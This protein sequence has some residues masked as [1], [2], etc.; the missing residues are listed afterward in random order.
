MIF[1]VGGLATFLW[2]TSGLS[3]GRAVAALYAGED[4]WI[5][6][7]ALSMLTLVGAAVNTSFAGHRREHADGRS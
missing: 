5:L 1:M 4:V 3:T 2:W 7:A 6:Y